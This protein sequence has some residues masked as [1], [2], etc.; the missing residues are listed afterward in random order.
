MDRRTFL[1]ELARLRTAA[2]QRGNLD[3]F[4]SESCD[5]CS[6]CMFCEDCTQCHACT[7]V[8]A[9]TGCTSLVHSAECEACHRGAHLIKCLRCVD[10]RYLIECTDCAACTYCFGCVGLVDKEFHILNTPYDRK[11][12]FEKVAELKTALG[13]Q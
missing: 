10:S 5:N 2:R 6:R 4:E 1:S 9:S 11:T 7:Y 12:Y 3:C 8:R 13:L